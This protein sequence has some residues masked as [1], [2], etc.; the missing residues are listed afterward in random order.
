MVGIYKITN[1]LGKSYIGLSKNIKLRFKSH[2][3]LQF[4]GNNKLRESLILHGGDSHL[5]EIIEEVNI[6]NL[7]FK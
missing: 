1:P 6:L 7:S 5:F 4:R 3:R 2:K